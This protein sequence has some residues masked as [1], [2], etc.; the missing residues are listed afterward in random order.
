MPHKLL[1]TTVVGSYPQPEW[2]IDRTALRRRLGSQN[3][4]AG[5][6]RIP[7]NTWRRPRMTPHGSPSGTWSVL[8]WTSS[9]TGKSDARATPTALLRPW[10]VSTLR[11]RAR[12]LAAAGGQLPCH[13]SWDPFGACVR[14]RCEM[15]SFCGPIPT[16]CIKATVPGPFTMA[17]Q[18]QNDY[19]P[20][21]ER[22]RWTTPPA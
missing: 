13:V 4:H 9:R 5:L 19:Y 18:A 2:L 17:Q 10:R 12:S 1:L 7:A 11:D 14:C 3:P 16:A 20:D 15:C 21:R 8:A 22:W 6:W